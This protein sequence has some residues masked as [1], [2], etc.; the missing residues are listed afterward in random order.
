MET[1]IKDILGQLKNMIEANRDMGLDP[2]PIS[3]EVLDYLNAKAP[4]RPVNPGRPERP[5]DSVRPDHPDSLEGLRA[6]IG[7]CRLCKLHKGR[8]NLVFGEGSPAARLVF[9][10]EG[11]G[12]DE[13][14]VGRPFVGVAGELL[15]DIIE[16]GMGLTREDVYICNVVKCHPPENRDPERDEIEACLPFLKQ[17][18]RIIQPEVICT[19]GRIASQELLEKGIK[20]TQDRGKWYSFMDI[21]VMPTYHPAYVKRNRSRERELKGHVWEDIKKIMKRLGLEVKKR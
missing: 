10:G 14:R 8:K 21:P 1:E 3:N 6:H 4:E 5:V 13:D 19:L 9:V 17:Q 16:K 12:R 2:P 7:D 20:I 11:P 15:T 18:I